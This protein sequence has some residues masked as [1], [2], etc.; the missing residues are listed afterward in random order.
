[1]SAIS[2]YQTNAIHIWD[3]ENERKIQFQ[4]LETKLNFTKYTRHVWTAVHMLVWQFRKFEMNKAM[5][6]TLKSKN[7]SVNT[8]TMMD[9]PSKRAF[10][11]L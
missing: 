10:S 7:L 5:W 1:M 2:K 11:I 4:F 8:L 9:L 6:R 3:D